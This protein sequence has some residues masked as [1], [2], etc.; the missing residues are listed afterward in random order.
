[1]FRRTLLVVAAA[2]GSNPSHFTQPDAARDGAALDT[3][4]DAPRDAAIDAAAPITTVSAGDLRTCALH[5]GVPECWG[6]NLG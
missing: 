5:A 2:C 1:M 3:P 4:P 6:Y